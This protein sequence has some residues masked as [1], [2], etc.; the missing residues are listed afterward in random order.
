[1][2]L[3]AFGTGRRNLDVAAADIGVLLDGPVVSHRGRPVRGARYRT[4]FVEVLHR[5]SI[6][7]DN[8]TRSVGPTDDLIAFGVGVALHPGA[9][10]TVSYFEITTWIV[11]PIV[12]GLVVPGSDRTV[13]LVVVLMVMRAD[14]PFLD[15]SVPI[16]G[17]LGSIRRL[18]LGGSGVVWRVGGIDGALLVFGMV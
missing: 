15:V 17:R 14:V 3:H 7:R 5:H 8:I 12:V 4:G 16:G 6:G 2:A 13:Q 18:V 11:N 1:M 9:R 10:L